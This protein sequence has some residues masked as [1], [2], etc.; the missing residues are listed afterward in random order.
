M[1]LNRGSSHT[2]STRLFTGP[3][4]EHMDERLLSPTSA[5]QDG[6]TL[7][8]T[9]ASRRS[10]AS[11]ATEEIVNTAFDLLPAFYHLLSAPSFFLSFLS[12]LCLLRSMFSVVTNLTNTIL[13]SGMLGLPHAFAECGFLQHPTH[14]LHRPFTAFTSSAG[15]SAP[16][17]WSSPPFPPPSLSTFSASR[18]R[19][20]VCLPT[21]T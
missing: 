13:G 20:W 10:R 7:S 8:G 9:V 15:F 11:L 14:F 16:S 2:R 19:R 4:T 1:C 3:E 17:S 12:C 21:T 18:P 6:R 5:S